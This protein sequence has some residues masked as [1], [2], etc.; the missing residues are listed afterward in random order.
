MHQTV[1]R[2]AIAGDCHTND[3]VVENRF[4]LVLVFFRFRCVEAAADEPDFLAG[5]GDEDDGLLKL[6]LAH[7]AGEFQHE[8]G[9]GGVIGDARGGGFD[10]FFEIDHIVG[11]GFAAFGR[12]FGGIGFANDI[13]RVVVSA[14]DDASC[15][16][17]WFP[18]ARRLH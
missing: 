18:A 5:E 16:A 4:N 3:V 6:V 8:R 7:H 13:Q 10:G 9:A 2:V 17:G 14:D 1:F 12:D 15:P 11:R